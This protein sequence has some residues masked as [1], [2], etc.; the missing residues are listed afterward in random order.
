MINFWNV[1]RKTSLELLFLLVFLVDD[2][3]VLLHLPI[4][5]DAYAQLEVLLD[6]MDNCHLQQTHDSWTYIWGSANYTS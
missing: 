4:S 2:L 5:S 6:D 1:K 3:N